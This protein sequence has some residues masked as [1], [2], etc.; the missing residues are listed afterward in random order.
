[1][2][3]TSNSAPDRQ[4]GVSVTGMSR[5]WRSELRSKTLT[6]PLTMFATYALFPRATLWMPAATGI[7]IAGARN[8]RTM[9]E[10]SAFTTET[11]PATPNPLKTFGKTIRE[12]SEVIHC[13]CGW[14]LPTPV[15]SL[16]TILCV[17]ENPGSS[18][19]RKIWSALSGRFRT[20][21]CDERSFGFVTVCVGACPTSIVARTSP[22]ARAILLCQRPNQWPL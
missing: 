7:V 20:S 4:S 16:S 15:G 5:R 11:D 12:P 21:N 22:V 14:F 18:I 19:F 13:P 10:F 17:E 8:S 6:W 1:M 2:S 9:F 3:K